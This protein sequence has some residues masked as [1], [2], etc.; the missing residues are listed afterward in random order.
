MAKEF[1][2]IKAIVDQ[3][4]EKQM[5]ISDFIIDHQSKELGKSPEELYKIM[6]DYFQVMIEGT[7]FHEE[8]NLPSTSGLT[9]GESEKIM[10]YAKN[11]NGG[12]AGPFFTKALARGVS[13]SNCNAAMGQIV[14]TPTAG[15]C[16]ILPGCLVTLMEDFDID[17]ETLV[18]S[19]FVAAGFGMVIA[20]TASIA[21]AEGGCQAECGSAAGMAAAAM[22]EVLGGTPA[23]SADACGMALINQLG[24]VCDPVAGLVEIP[25]I[26]R[27][28][29][30]IAIAL[31][32]T[33]MAMAGVDLY[34]PV[35]EVIAAMKKIGDT[36]PASLKETA[37][38]GLAQTE[39]GRALRN[40]VF[41]KIKEEAM[42]D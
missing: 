25:C 9:G 3:A 21:G 28:A 35:D 20:K 22:V 7:H 40:K 5:K 38:G 32:A 41:G 8:D 2:S 6:D 19:L 26:K 27:N 14:A 36:L 17:R 4:Q 23:Q 12:F 42:E 33:T 15:S 16:G 24:L 10:A 34:I 31:A 1:Y 30:S 18:R 39:T 13:V 37:G 29:G 11:N